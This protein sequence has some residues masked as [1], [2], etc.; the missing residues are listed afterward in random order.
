MRKRVDPQKTVNGMA[1]SIEQE[2][3][4]WQDIQENGCSDPF[5]PDG[6]NM[7]LVRNHILYY[8][9]QIMTTCTEN[10]LTLPDEYY[11]PTPPKVTHSYMANLKQRKRVERLRDFGEKLDVGNSSSYDTTQ[12]SFL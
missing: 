5:W 6:T 11:T 7:N 9:E 1:V 10:G 2:A 8:K 3:M 12:L 4:R